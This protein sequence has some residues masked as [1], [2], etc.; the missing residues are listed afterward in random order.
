MSVLKKLLNTILKTVIFFIGWVILILISPN[1]Q[2]NNDGFLRLW[3]EFTPFAAVVL[4]SIVFV[5]VIEKEKIKIPIVSSGLKNSMIGIVIGIIWLGS[6]VVV[7]FLTNTMNIVGFNKVNYIW[8][9][10][11]ASLFNVMMQELLVRGYLYNLW[12]SK[13]HF[14]VATI[15]TTVLFTAM[16]GGAFEAGVIPVINVITMSIFATI[17]LEYTGTL[18]APIM[19]HF[20]WNTMG[21]II[22]G[23]VS[24]ASDY[25]N[26]L[27]ST[28]QGNPLLSGGIYKLEGSIVVLIV[29]L[30]LIVYLIQ[31]Q[32]NKIKQ[33]SFP[34]K[35]NRNAEG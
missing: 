16:H 4:L 35:L 33:A 27:R 6:V 7:L 9:W 5:S 1:I 12:K 13:Y 20:I 3:W 14:S 26:L 32:K 28:F 29:N 24:L 11:L 2:T 31:A 15:L 10:I 23:G 34:I 30:I 22:F 21:A 19:A 25:P 17:L 18:V 8:I